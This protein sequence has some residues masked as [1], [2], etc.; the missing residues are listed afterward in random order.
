[1]QNWPIFW[2]L[3]EIHRHSQIL[4]IHVGI[5]YCI[6]ITNKNSYSASLLSPLYVRLALLLEAYC[7]G[8]SAHLKSMIKQVEMISIL[9][10]LCTSIRGCGNKETANK[11]LQ[12]E[13]MARKEQMQNMV[14][15]VNAT[16]RLGELKVEECRVL[17]S[18]KQP[19]LLTWNNPESLAELTSPTHQLIFKCGDDMRQDML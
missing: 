7:R 19:L 10:T 18:A 8:N 6:Y 4:P 13:L 2:Q 5:N 12:Q 17:G 15:P 11:K 14:S 16:D 3:T 1:M 9:T